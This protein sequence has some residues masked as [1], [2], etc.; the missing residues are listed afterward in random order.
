MW[1]RFLRHGLL[2]ACLAVV[3]ACQEQGAAPQ[4]LLVTSSCAGTAPL[5]G[6]THLRLRVTGEGLS[7]P[8]ERITPVNIRPEDVPVVPPGTRRM[9]EVRGYTGE[10]TSAGKVVSVGR[11]GPFDMPAE[12][13]PANPVRVVLRRV[14]TFAPVESAQQ[15][16]TCL[17]LT[18][19]RAG[20]T[21]TLLPDGQVVLVGGFR[22]S[23]SGAVET[24]ASVELFDPMSRTQDFVQALGAD[25]ARR[26]FHTASLMLDGRV[27]LVG[28]EVQTGTGTTPLSSV[29]VF[30][31]ATRDTQRFSLSE[32]RTRHAAAVDR[33]GRVLVVGGEGQGGT[34]LATPEGVEP[35]AGRSFAV[36]TPLPRVG[37]SVAALPDGQRLVVAGGSDGT[38][39]PRE[40]LTFSFNGTTFA[41]TSTGLQLRQSRRDAALVPYQTD[42]SRLLMVG[43][44]GSEGVPDASSKPVSLSEIIDLSADRAGVLVG[45]STVARGDLCAVPLPDGRV[46]AMGG[47]RPADTVLASTGLSELITPT[48][49]VTGGVLG[50]EPVAPRFLHTCTPLPDGSVFVT[51]GLD[52]GGGDSR[53]AQDVLVF[54]PVP[55]D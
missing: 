2:A 36:P 46:L 1:L 7:A 6:V 8:I 31:P 47:R 35:A 29:A 14:D 21:A 3:P 52:T 55:L 26:A 34:V 18:E 33:S 40:V 22:L 43:G 9:L 12:G 23:A 38:Q 49:N 37:V 24:L 4:L 27:A 28:G 50:M 5:E 44:Y 10:P 45:P 51:G 19:P 25:A 48:P 41:P 30:N 16:G 15:P 39:L 32:P 42:G 53:L 20:H 13:A 11:S 17:Q 54:M